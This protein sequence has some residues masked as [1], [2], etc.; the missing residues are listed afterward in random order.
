MG[1]DKEM[2]NCEFC[3]QMHCSY[4][5]DHCDNGLAAP[6]IQKCKE[7]EYNTMLCTLYSVLI[8][9]HHFDLD[10]LKIIQ[11]LADYSL[12]AV[13]CCSKSDC[14]NE[15]C[16]DYAVEVDETEDMICAKCTS[17]DLPRF[18]DNLRKES[19]FDN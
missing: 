6:V 4:C 15:I 1:D 13:V 17:D 16:L 12:G 14:Q 7:N 11:I 3:H 9:E 10:D 8:D 2:Q 19:K 18:W 5:Y